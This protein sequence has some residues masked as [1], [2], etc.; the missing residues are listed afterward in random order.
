MKD[1]EEKFKKV[2]WRKGKKKNQKNVDPQMRES[3]YFVDTT[4]KKKIVFFIVK[5]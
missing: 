4:E 3:P 2:Q 5:I 1:Q